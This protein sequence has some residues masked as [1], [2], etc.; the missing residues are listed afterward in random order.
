M[1]QCLGLGTGVGGGC[2]EDWWHAECLLEGTK[3]CSEN[4]IGSGERGGAGDAVADTV[5]EIP[6]NSLPCKEDHNIEFTTQPITNVPDSLRDDTIGRSEAMDTTLPPEFP[7]EDDFE[8]LI[9]YKCTSAFPWII[10][11][12]GRPGFLAAIPHVGRLTGSGKPQTPSGVQI[13]NLGT[14][15]GAAKEGNRKRKAVDGEDEAVTERSPKRRPSSPAR[16]LS[17]PAIS[18]KRPKGMKA[19]LH[20]VSLFLTAEFRDA[21]CRCPACF[22]LLIGHP[23]LL[24]EEETYEPPLSASS[25]SETGNAE[26]GA[27]S[28]G[29]RSLLERGEAALSNMDRVRAIEG[30]MAYNQL[31]DKVKYFLKPFAETGTEVGAEDIKRYFEKLRGD[32]EAIRDAANARAMEQGGVDDGGGGPGRGKGE[33]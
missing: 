20:L 10:N 14:N 31:R 16:R 32:E 8:H 17:P 19:S 28:A 33:F 26:P 11:Y 4:A 25:G 13:S 3:D 18:C 23:P 22:P 21:I 7:A 27:R 1:F 29:S 9:C 30:V 24:D 12:A 5:G 6:A 15:E 2:G